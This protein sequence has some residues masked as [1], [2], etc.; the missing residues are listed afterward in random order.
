[1]LAW[2]GNR[3]SPRRDRLPHTTI[4]GKEV[5]EVILDARGSTFLLEVPTGERAFGSYEAFAA[6][7]EKELNA[8]IFRD[9]LGRA[10]GWELRLEQVDEVVALDPSMPDGFRLVDNPIAEYLGGTW[11]YVLIDGSKHCVNMELCADSID[12]PDETEGLVG[13]NDLS[14][15]GM[16]LAASAE[17]Y[18]M[19]GTSRLDSWWA[20]RTFANQPLPLYYYKQE[21]TSTTTLEAWLAW[22]PPTPYVTPCITDAAGTLRP[23]K[24]TPRYASTHTVQNTDVFDGLGVRTTGK[25]LETY[26]TNRIGMRWYLEVKAEAKGF[27]PAPSMI[28]GGNAFDHFNEWSKGTENGST[29]DFTCFGNGC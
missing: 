13:Q 27:K 14:A 12:S 24:D 25:R 16:L 19:F 11:G 15:A 21:L 18:G 20:N 5:G 3:P 17:G 22:Q 4:A 28:Y 8:K 1:M 23:C 29:F 26:D 10:I 6:F 2:W 7:L 9:G